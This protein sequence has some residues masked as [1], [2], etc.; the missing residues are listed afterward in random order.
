MQE[1][2]GLILASRSPR[3]RE[4]LAHLAGVDGF[5]VFAPP[6]SEELGFEDCHDLESIQARMTQIARGKIAQV[7]THSQ[8]GDSRAVLGADTIVVAQ[9][10][11]GSLVVL[12]QP[13]VEGD[14]KAVVREWFTRYYFQRPHLVLTSVTLDLGRE[15]KSRVVRT[16]VSFRADSKGLVEWYLSTGE[17]LGKAGGYGIQGA[18][19][20]FIE[21]VEGSLTNVIGLPMFETRELLEEAGLLV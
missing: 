4:L 5:E 18:A 20:V 12:G 21:R 17:S 19:G 8:T 16:E 13:P 14:W 3:R 9:A 11:D 7:R 2:S 10:D 6:N 1:N 15:M